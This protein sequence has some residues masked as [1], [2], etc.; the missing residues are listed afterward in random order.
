LQKGQALA[1]ISLHSMEYRVIGLMSGS[2]LDGLDIAYCIINEAGGKWQYTIPHAE[3]I[4]FDGQLT[5]RLRDITQASLE[6]Y[7]SLDIELGKFYANAINTFIEKHSLQHKVHLVCSHGHTTLHRPSLGYSAQ[8]GCGATMAALTSLP[9]INNLRMVDVALGGQ[10]APIVPI[11]EQLLFENYSAFLNIGGICNISHHQVDKI[12]AYD[13][14]AA[15]RVLNTLANRLNMPYDKDGQLAQ[16]GSING[17]ALNEINML[18]YFAQAAPKSLA[19][20]FGIEQVLPILDQHCVK[21]ED[22]I[23]S[24]TEHIAIQVAEA[25][26]HM[27]NGEKILVS[28]GGAFNTYLI[29]R[30]RELCG[31]NNITV[32]VAD[33]LTIEYK[34]ALAMALIGVLRWREENNVINSVTGASRSSVGGALWLS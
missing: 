7:L 18:P 25:S 6:D 22:A 17:E 11:A 32:D 13:V 20:E 31:K 34:E 5:N 23:A 10:G 16:T 12:V 27:A 28:G 3:C 19:N 30:M 21:A 8:I 14:C 4:S 33:T 29:N 26:A 24:M 9:V 1:L 2:S 15:N